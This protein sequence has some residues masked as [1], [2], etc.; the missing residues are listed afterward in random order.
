ML[1]GLQCLC[2]AAEALLRADK[3]FRPR[4]TTITLLA[5]IFSA[6]G[7]NRYSSHALQTRELIC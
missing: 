2:R 1:Q 7:V 5:M 4:G 6:V 3:V